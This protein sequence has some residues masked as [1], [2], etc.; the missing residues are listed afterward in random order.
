VL[1][2]F[3]VSQP[4]ELVGMDMIGKVA[5][6][7]AGNTYILVTVDY[8]TKWPEAFALPSKTAA[9]VADCIIRFFYRFGAP[10][11]ILTDQGRE[12]VNEVC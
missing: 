9:N 3:K 7:E 12:F 5:E 4:F 8:F 1:S 2:I 10:K 6:T 11:R